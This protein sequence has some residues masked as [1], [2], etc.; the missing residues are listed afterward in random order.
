MH[1]H[2]TSSQVFKAEVEN[3][4]GKKIKILRQD[5]G[6]EYYGGYTAKFLEIHIISG[7]DQIRNL[8]FCA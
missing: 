1:Y 2:P 8:V 6:G 4:C 5:R 7:S 3:K